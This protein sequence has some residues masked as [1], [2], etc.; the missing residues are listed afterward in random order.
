MEAA[1]RIAY[2]AWDRLF[3]LGQAG[4]EIMVTAAEDIQQAQDDL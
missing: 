3:T 2:D 1:Q 4:A